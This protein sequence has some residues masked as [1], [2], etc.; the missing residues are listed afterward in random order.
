MTGSI[1][2]VFLILGATIALFVSDRVR[3]DLVALLSLLALTLTGSITPAQAAGA[4]GDPLVIIIAALFVVSGGL[5]RTG[6][7]ARVGRLLG[8]LAGRDEVRLIALTMLAVALLSSFMSSTGAVAVMLPVVV[9]LAWDA[10]ISPSKLLMPLSLGS[11]FGGMLTLIGTPPNL[12]VSQQLKSAGLEP[13]NF[14]AFTPPGLAVLAVGLAFMLVIGRRL[15]P[16]RAP[17]SQGGRDAAEELSTRELADIYGLPGQLVHLRVRDDSPLAGRC[18]RDADLRA[19][20][21][22]SVLAIRTAGGEASRPMVPETCFEGGDELF[23]QG[24]AAAV[25]EMAAGEALEPVDG[26]SLLPGN[27]GLVEVLLTP[28]SR[29]IGQTLRELRFRERF[30]VTVAGIQRV[31]RAVEGDLA[32]VRLRFGDTLLVK[33]PWSHID[34]LQGQQRDFVVVSHPPKREHPDPSERRAPI[35]ILILLGMLVV[36]TTGVLPTFTAVLLAAVAMVA[37]GC[38]GMEEAYRSVNWQSV[39][40]IAAMLPMATALEASGGMQLIVD[41][42][43]SLGGSGPLLMMAVLFVVTSL[44]SQVM[45]NTA[46]TVLLAPIAFQAAVALGTSPHALLMAVAIAASTAFSTPIASPTNTIVL[47]AGAYRFGDYV[48]VGVPLQLLTLVVTL[49]VVPAVFPL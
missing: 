44:L 49:L 1:L 18:L 39:V 48:K 27:L 8:R 21:A 40:L 33:G 19:R 38:L 25:R 31:G 20:Y 6:V 2:T 26:R 29:L 41:G 11:L 46:T 3:L 7:A 36:M 9:A 42:L 4:F 32:D 37:T 15:L 43:T 35:A 34:L 14:F 47:S 45:S 13:F 30:R 22:V 28:R 10:G 16:S 5:F 17:A 24:S 12:V 23:V